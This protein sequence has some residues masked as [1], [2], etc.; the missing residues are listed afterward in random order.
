MLCNTLRQ[1][2][3]SAQPV[4][5]EALEL[6]LSASTRTQGTAHSVLHPP[7]PTGGTSPHT[8]PEMG[9]GEAAVSS[10]GTSLRAPPAGPGSAQGSEPVPTLGCSTNQPRGNVSVQRCKSE[11][12]V[13]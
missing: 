13:T 4:L 5:N 2:T 7:S 6:Q 12:Q 9:A 8:D 11:P 1:Y 10:A 3:Q